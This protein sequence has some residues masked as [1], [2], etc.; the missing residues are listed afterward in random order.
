[1]AVD[2]VMPRMGATMTEGT[3]VR[4][5]K[6]PGETVRKEEAV[7]EIE[8]DKST[9]E[10]TAPADGVLGPW[11]AEVGAVVPIGGPLVVVSGRSE[12]AE[13]Q[14]PEIKASPVAKR[15]ARSYGIDLAHVP[16]TGPGG[17]IIEEDVLRAVAAREEAKPAQP[18]LSSEPARATPAAPAAGDREILSGLRRTVAERMALSFATAPH[19]YLHVEADASALVAWYQRAASKA[20]AGTPALTYTDLFLFLTATALREHPRLTASWDAGAIQYHPDINLGMAVD[21]TKG[22]VVP[23]I[24]NAGRLTL[25]ELARRRAELVTRAQAGRLLPDDYTGGTF[26]LTNLGMFGV[27]SFQAILNPPQSAILALGRIKPRPFVVDDALVA[28]PTLHLNLS[29]DHRVL[30]GAEAA[31]F[32]SRLVELIEAPQLLIA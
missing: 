31:R 18:A 15:V 8:T 11:L 24:Q 29:A 21:T 20:A 28:R 26:T 3:I 5:L 23:V 19:F 25:A 7:V 30:D 27:D 6:R 22:L 32:L 10:L 17:R 12:A 1:M 9:V 2:L 4:W 14:E 13:A 16:G